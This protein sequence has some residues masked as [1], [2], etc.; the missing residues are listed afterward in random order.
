MDELTRWMKLADLAELTVQYFIPRGQD[1]QHLD[2]IIHSGA[3]FLWTGTLTVPRNIFQVAARSG[4]VE[5]IFKDGY[6]RKHYAENIA[7][8][9]VESN[10]LDMLRWIYANTDK[11]L[12]RPEISL[13][14]CIH[15]GNREMRNFIEQETKIN[16]EK[17][18]HESIRGAETLESAF[19]VFIELTR[20]PAASMAELLP[21]LVRLKAERP[22]ML[23]EPVCLHLIELAWDARNVPVA[24]WL[25]ESFPAYWTD[26][27]RS[28]HAK[29]LGG[30]YLPSA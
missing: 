8:A 17:L 19:G 20:R 22:E 5:A 13:S 3:L 10:K 29:F 4:H 9:A 6:D 12:N 7:E 27:H 2:Y 14:Y 26:Q 24:N 18:L 16:F 11:R 28:I 30:H 21:Y 25:M 1:R 23:D 15:H